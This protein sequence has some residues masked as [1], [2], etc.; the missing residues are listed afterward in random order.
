MKVLALDGSGR[1]TRQAAHDTRADANRSTLRAE[2]RPTP[3]GSEP[4][5][6]RSCGFRHRP[7]S[8]STHS[9]NAVLCQ[10]WEAARRMRGAKVA[11]LQRT[12]CGHDALADPG[13][14]AARSQGMI[15]EQP[16]AAERHGQCVASYAHLALDLV[17]APGIINSQRPRAAFAP[18]DVEDLLAH[19]ALARLND[20]REA[21]S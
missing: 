5:A 7:A 11:V 15:G 10:R 8:G 2:P 6:I 14:R 17:D 3:P 4:F 18:D 20:A 13:F 12:A 9:S 19:R 1:R 16:G 21:R